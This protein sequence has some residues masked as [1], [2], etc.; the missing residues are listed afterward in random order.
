MGATPKATVPMKTEWKYIT[1][2]D[3]ESYTLFIKRHTHDFWTAKPDS[4]YHYTSGETLI[5]IVQSGEL[6]TTH[7]ACLND[8]KEFVYAFDRLKEHIQTRIASARSA[9]VNST[10][11][12]SARSN[13]CALR[14]GLVTANPKWPTVPKVNGT[15]MLV[16]LTN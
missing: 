15:F 12:P 1:K 6:W 2:T 10:D 3:Q 9:E 8:M 7:I 11:K 16:T 5:R 14:F 13:H 4:L